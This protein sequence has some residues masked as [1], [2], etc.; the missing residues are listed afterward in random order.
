MR[1]VPRQIVLSERSLSATLNPE[2]AIFL[3]QVV[4]GRKRQ[5]TGRASPDNL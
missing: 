5:H 4:V 1:R 3:T 2:R